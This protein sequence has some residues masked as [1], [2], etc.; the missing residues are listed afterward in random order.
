MAA[1]KV[2]RPQVIFVYEK[3]IGSNEENTKP[4]WQLAE[5]RREHDKERNHFLTVIASEV[6]K[7]IGE[8]R[9]EA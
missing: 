8:A 9:P 4:G 7:I 3:T 2:A 5:P 1:S 6:A